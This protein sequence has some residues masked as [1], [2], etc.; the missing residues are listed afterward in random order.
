[1]KMNNDI[2]DLNGTM[3]VGALL[4]TSALWI[5]AMSF[6]KR[7]RDE[8]EE[9]ALSKA[10]FLTVNNMGVIGIMYGMMAFV[11]GSFLIPTWHVFM[12]I[13]LGLIMMAL[14]YRI[15]LVKDNLEP[16]FISRMPKERKV[17]F[18]RIIVYSINF[19]VL[20]CLVMLSFTHGFQF[21]LNV[22]ALVMLWYLS[23]I[24]HIN[25]PNKKIVNTAE[26]NIVNVSLLIFSLVISVYLL[27]DK[28]QMLKSILKSFGTILGQ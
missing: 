24:I 15:Y 7:K 13:T 19:G 3:L 21:R 14:M 18:Y 5:F 23:Y 20:V 17:N 6:L 16:A 22:M 12:L 1:M 27:S 25:T 9:Q 28:T 26:H 4:L 11:N 8:R 2:L 10:A